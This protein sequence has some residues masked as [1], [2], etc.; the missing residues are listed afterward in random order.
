M[1]VASFA[2]WWHFAV[3]A[4]EPVGAAGQVKGVSTDSVQTTDLSLALYPTLKVP[5]NFKVAAKEYVLF[6]PESGKFLL[7]SSFMEP[8]PIASTTKYMTAYLTMKYDKPDD[9][10]TI[11]QEAATRPQPSSLMGIT[12]GQKI[13]VLNLLRGALMVSGNDA[14]Y[15]L[16]EYTGGILV[17]DQNVTSEAK[18]AR[19]VT[20]M[21][22]TASNL[23]LTQTK[24]TDPTGFDDLGRSTAKDL[25]K[26]ASVVNQDPLIQ[27]IIGTPLITVYDVN[28][29]Y[30]FD[31]RNS[32]R[33]TSDFL[34][35]GNIGGKTGFTYDAGHCLINAAQR[36]GHTLIVVVLHTDQDTT[37]AS[38]NVARQ[39][40]D[41]GFNQ[42]VWY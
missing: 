4:A 24:Y 40:I 11:S 22:T 36:N 15:A 29:L 16:A 21:N 18:V 37:D 12:G 30:R 33:F 10:V 27:Q 9:V 35:D 20:E 39:I 7:E 32:D 34:Y 8:V 6:N 28:N 26:L 5:I 19:F 25:A 13:T 14:A 23:F 31:L 17:H 42:T 3:L 41:L 38:A 1:V 2:G